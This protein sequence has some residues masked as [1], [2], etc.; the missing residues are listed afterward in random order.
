MLHGNLISETEMT[1][2]GIIPAQQEKI[3]REA[4]G[5]LEDITAL[6]WQEIYNHLIINQLF[7]QYIL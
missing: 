2:E 1:T 7:K 3:E 5:M 6:T 4:V